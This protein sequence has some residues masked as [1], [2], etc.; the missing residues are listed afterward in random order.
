MN[1]DRSVEE[2]KQVVLHV[3][4]IDKVEVKQGESSQEVASPEVVV[5]EFVQVEETVQPAI[6]TQMETPIE[7]VVQPA[8]V[9]RLETPIEAVAQPASATSAKSTTK[10]KMLKWRIVPFV[11]N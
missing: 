9:T 1:T 7:A 6:V 2:L 5:Q 10:T 3:S 11:F 4:E 8:M